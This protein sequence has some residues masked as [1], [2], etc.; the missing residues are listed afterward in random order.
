[1]EQGLYA[2]VIMLIQNYFK[3]TQENNNKNEDKFK[4][5]GHSVR[6]QSWFDFIFIGMKKA[7]AHMNLVSIRKFSKV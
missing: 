7:L 4:F 5:Q 2:Q 3:I 6:S 1:M